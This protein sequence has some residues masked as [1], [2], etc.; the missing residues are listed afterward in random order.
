MTSETGG[1]AVS[2]LTARQRAPTPRTLVD[3]FGSTAARHPDVL[4]VDSGAETLTYAEL[5]E[6]AG[7]VAAR[8]AD[9]GVGP[10][11][12]VGVRIKSGT[13]DLYVAIL[14]ILL[15]GA[16][17]VPVDAD[18]PDERAR[19]VFTESAVAAVIGNDLALEVMARAREPRPQAQVTPG[20]DAWVIF[21]SGSTG[22]PKGVAV[23]HRSA[24]AFVD[25]EARLFLRGDGNGGASIVDCCSSD[26]PGLVHLLT[27][28]REYV[29]RLH[30]EGHTVGEDHD[31]DPVVIDPAGRAVDWPRRRT[32][33]RS[34]CCTERTQESWES[35]TTASWL[36]AS[37]RSATDGAAAEAPRPSLRPCH[38]AERR[39]DSAGIAVRTRYSS[40]TAQGVR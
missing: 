33:S 9:A 36:A 32:T 39:P 22:T 21:T 20:D 11:D 35:R 13:V 24:A 16:A 27:D 2:S 18:D 10:G 38:V 7:D 14:G 28:V 17:Y 26:R 37:T 3:I 19:V 34:I 8:L 30:I 6:A 31:D 1:G 23:T 5:E 15:A 29:D 25:A 40:P 12:K 4:A